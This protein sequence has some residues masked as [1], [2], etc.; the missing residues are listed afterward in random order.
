[1]KSI[2]LALTL[3][4]S[5]LTTS[6]AGFAQQRDFTKVEIKTTKITDNFYA[7]EGEGGRIGILA[8]PDGI[9]MVDTQFAQISDRILAAIRQ[10]SDAPFRILVNTHVHG[11]HTG[12]NAN[13]ARQGATIMARPQLRARLMNPSAPPGVK[14]LPPAPAQ[15]LP[16]VTYDTETTLHMNGEAV[17]LI[18]APVAHTDGDTLVYFP[19]ANVIMTGDF[20]RS[21]GFPNIDIINGGTLNG[22][23]ASFETVLKLGPANAVIAPGHGPITN[24]AAVAEH[25]DMVIAVR[26]KV[27][28]LI[29]QGKTQDEVVAA[30]TAA[31]FN[32]KV[33]GIAFNADRFVIQIYQQLKAGR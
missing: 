14:P 16:V 28:A 33:G 5:A 2:L 25:R 7:L 3:A 9:L 20:F 30:Q 10:I 15:A 32:A 1:M 17:R 13:F 4:L 24:K 8:G 6:T 23:L 19:K 12:G 18:P 26:D 21:V 31:D 22:L 11:D 29:K 27:D